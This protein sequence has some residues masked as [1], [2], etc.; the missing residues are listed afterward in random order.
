[1]SKAVAFVNAHS[2]RIILSSIGV[3]ELY[4]GVK[5]D[6]EQAVLENF[7]ALFRLVPVFR[8]S[9]RAGSELRTPNFF[10]D[11]SGLLFNWRMVYLNGT[12]F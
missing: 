4:A 1:M 10:H 8:L 11:C 6:A 2:T 3:A 7:I 9:T 12:H 5:G